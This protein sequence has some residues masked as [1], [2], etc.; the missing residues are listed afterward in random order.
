MEIKTNWQTRGKVWNMGV[1][2]VCVCVR[3][4][5][6]SLREALPLSHPGWLTLRRSTLPSFRAFCCYHSRISSQSRIDV[7]EMLSLYCVHA[8]QTCNEACVRHEQNIV[9][10]IHRAHEHLKVNTVCWLAKVEYIPVITMCSCH[11]CVL[12]TATRTAA[13][14]KR[15]GAEML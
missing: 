3:V 7:P 14:T 8:A 15:T 4:C 5:V 11:C 6:C 13:C 2:R 1:A 9:H 10:S 12:A